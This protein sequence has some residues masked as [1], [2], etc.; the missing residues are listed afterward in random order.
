MNKIFNVEKSQLHKIYTIAGI[1]IKIIDI[2]LIKSKLK[3]LLD[4]QWRNREL[5]RNYQFFWANNEK[6]TVTQKIWYLSELFYRLCGYFPDFKHP[7]SLNE[8]LNWLKFN[9]YDP[10]LLKIVDKYEFKQ[11]IKENLGDGYTI[12]LIGV[13]E[14]VNDIDFDKLPQKFVIKTTI[15]NGGIGCQLVKDKNKINID[16]LKYTFN[17]LMQE[18]NSPFFQ[19]YQPGFKSIQPRIIIEEYMPI[20]E[21]AA[22]EY[23]M[24]CFQGEMKFCLIECDYFGK[25]PARAIY[26]KQFKELPFTIRRLPKRTLKEKPQLYEE[27]IT[28]AERLAATFPF[29]R[30]DFYVIN[31]KIYLSEL[32]FNSGAGFSVFTPT[33][34]DYKLGEWLDLTKLN[35][36][37]INILDEFK[38]TELGRFYNKD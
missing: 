6:Y 15:G 13:Y 14:D 35:P 32:T 26:D 29:V 24:F 20:R 16:K 5:A 11:Y 8:K 31:N 30:V 18:W 12:P 21:G 36:E 4:N 22:L 7:K 2:D 19:S 10:R 37:Y 38:N 23:K 34:W 28:I 9:Y 3:L 25:K 1:K 17:N 27:M 33:E